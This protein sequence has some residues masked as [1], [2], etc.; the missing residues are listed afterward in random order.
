MSIINPRGFDD[1]FDGFSEWA[2]R[3]SY[4]IQADVPQFQIVQPM[5]S[6]KFDLAWKDWAMCI[7]GG[8]DRL[9]QDSPNPWEFDTWREWA[10]RLFETQNFLG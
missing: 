6:D 4:L 3:M 7:V 1:D 10:E 2:D 5:D 9:G 8:Q